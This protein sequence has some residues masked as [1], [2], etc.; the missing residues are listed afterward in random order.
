MHPEAARGEAV[1]NSLFPG[2]GLMY[3][4]GTDAIHRLRRDLSARRGPGFSLKGFHDE[5]LR[6][7]SLPVALVA[8]DLLGRSGAAQA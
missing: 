8:A 6:Y 2:T 1:K 4:A 7:G 3:L 5:L